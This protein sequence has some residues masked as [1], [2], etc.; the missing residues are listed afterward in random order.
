MPCCPYLICFSLPL[1][2]IAQLLQEFPARDRQYYLQA[3][4][5]GRLRVEGAQVGGM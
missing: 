3:L 4:A 2:L 5:D 1:R